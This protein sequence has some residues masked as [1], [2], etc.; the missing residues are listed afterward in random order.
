MG[1][2]SVK[3]RGTTLLV[4]LNSTALLLDLFQL[5]LSG[6]VFDRLITLRAE[7][8]SVKGRGRGNSGREILSRAFTMK[9][10]IF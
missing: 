10:K 3:S 6:V 2:C 4:T 7:F 1:L 9:K 5:G 8:S